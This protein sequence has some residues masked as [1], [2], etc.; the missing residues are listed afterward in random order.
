MTNNQPNHNDR[1][2]LRL[3]C[4]ITRT[5]S[6][7]KSF[8]L[9]L[10]CLFT[11]HL[12]AQINATAALDSTQLLIGDKV[13]LR[14]QVKHSTDI[15][16]NDLDLSALEEAE[17]FEVNEVSPWD[18]LRAD[19]LQKNITIQ[20]F[21]SGYHFIPPIPILYNRNGE[22]QKVT[23]RRLAFTVNTIAQDS[24]QLA[25]I[26]PIEEEPRKLEDYLWL[27]IGVLVLGILIGVLRYFMKRKEGTTEAVVP[28]IKLPAHEIALQQ[29]AALKAEKLWQKG[30]VKTYHS[31]L[32]R[33]V[34]EYLENRYDIQALEMTTHQILEQLSKLDFD[35]SRRD[36][37]QEMLQ[38]ADLVKFAKAEP[39]QEFHERMMEYAEQ[40]V[41]ETKK[42]E[43]VEEQDGSL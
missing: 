23:T 36:R 17:G 22:S 7:L 8:F 42:V 19:L 38:A 40:F 31:R 9:L 21:D 15:Q 5:K 28:E 20:S 30:E 32:T 10:L 18:T 26:K 6:E 3:G 37:L 43:V 11:L 25:P 16:V 34:R 24:L 33:I 2:S 27:I 35:D 29:L 41:E 39:A 4:N 12:Q 13:Q 1:P 14:V